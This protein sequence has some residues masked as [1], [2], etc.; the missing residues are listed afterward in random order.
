M[1]HEERIN[2]P[3]GA[4]FSVLIVMLSAYGVGN[5]HIAKS[6]SV[7][8]EFAPVLA[9]MFAAVIVIAAWVLLRVARMDDETLRQRVDELRGHAAPKAQAPQRTGRQST[10]RQPQAALATSAEI[11]ELTVL[12]RSVASRLDA[13]TVQP[14]PVR[15]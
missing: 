6:G 3:Y 8:D 7:M 4:I 10:S 11:A 9:A 1:N 5:Q 13:L 2:I 14:V 15:A 12:L